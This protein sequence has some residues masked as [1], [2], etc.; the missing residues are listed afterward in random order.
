MR[1]QTAILLSM[2]MIA[3][4]VSGCTGNSVTQETVSL[5]EETSVQEQ[6]E[7]GEETEKSAAEQVMDD[8]YA[9]IADQQIELEL[10]TGPDWKGVYDSSVEGGDYLDFFNFVKAEFEEKYP[11]IKVNPVLIDGSQRAE[12]LAIAIQSGTLPNMYYES[13]FALSD[14]VHE[15]L[16][17]PLDDIV[18]DE[19]RADIPAA[20]WDSLELGG[21]TYIFPFSAEIG[22][23]GINVSIFKEAGAEEYLPEGEIGEWTPE[24]FKAALEAVK[25]VENVYPFAVFANSQQGDSFTNMLLRMYGGKFVNDEGNAFTINDEKGVQALQMIVDMK[26][27]GLLAPGGE[28]LSQ[29]D[30]YQMFLNKNLAVVTLNNLTYSNFAHRFCLCTLKI[31]YLAGIRLSKFTLCPMPPEAVSST[32]QA[33]CS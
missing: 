28:T 22:M 9:Q 7:T 23:L 33:M 10:W 21:E 30:V 6:G 13:D 16:M 11:N 3:G 8:L 24:E 5:P 20:V 18:T 32:K 1:K 14:Y 26:N 27:E 2:G 15:G 25:G 29:G 17:V 31:Q 4:L 19:D 12:K